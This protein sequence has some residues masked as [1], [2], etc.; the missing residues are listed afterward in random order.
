MLAPFIPPAAAGSLV[1]K[2]AWDKLNERAALGR[3]S[4]SLAGVL[5]A[6]K[7]NTQE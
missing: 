4:R 2:Y 3:A 6:A 7:K 1:G 5:S